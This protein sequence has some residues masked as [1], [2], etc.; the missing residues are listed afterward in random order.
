LPAFTCGS[1]DSSFPGYMVLTIGYAGLLGLDPRW[2]ANPIYWVITWHLL[3]GKVKKQSAMPII[4][5]ALSVPAI[6]IH[7]AGCKGGGGAPGLTTGLAVG[8]YLWV[9]AIAIV[10]AAY[11]A[12]QS[13]NG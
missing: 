5:L 9:T 10:S 8:G 3:A 1:G 2:F 6:F 7:A 13:R 11:I 12:M 4:A